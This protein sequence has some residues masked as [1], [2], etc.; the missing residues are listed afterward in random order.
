MV[1]KLAG[2]EADKLGCLRRQCLNSKHGSKVERD[3]ILKSLTELRSGQ[4]SLTY[5]APL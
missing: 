1:A 5:A 4:H 3:A 2:E